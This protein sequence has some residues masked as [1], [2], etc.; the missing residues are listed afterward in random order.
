M[1]LE[2]N[3]MILY[4]IR[5]KDELQKILSKLVLELEESK[6]AYRAS[7]MP[8]SPNNPDKVKGNVYG[9]IKNSLLS[10]EADLEKEIWSYNHRIQQANEKKRSWMKQCPDE[11]KDFFWD[12][13]N[14]KKYV[15][16]NDIYGYT[17]SQNHVATILRKLR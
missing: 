3:R 5:H 8:K 4:D 6:T 12:V 2:R 9:D 10:D 14:G 1:S 15:D 7:G 11:D 17:T 13:L 16:I